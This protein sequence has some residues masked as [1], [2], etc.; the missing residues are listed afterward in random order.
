M[1]NIHGSRCI[2]IISR[3][4]VWIGHTEVSEDQPHA[5]NKVKH[6]RKNINDKKEI[7]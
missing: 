7:L 4:V 3:K 5:K 6:K 2:L 1:L